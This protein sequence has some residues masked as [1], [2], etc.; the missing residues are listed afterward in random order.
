MSSMSLVFIWL[1]Q[2]IGYLPGGNEKLKEK[3]RNILSPIKQFDKPTNCFDYLKD[4]IKDK[5]VL[6]LTT[7]S[8]A[9]QDFLHSIAS[10]PNVIF[11]YI[12]DTSNQDYAINDQIIQQKMGEQRIIHFDEILYE[13]LIT[14]L[15]FLYQNQGEIL[16]KEKQNKEAKQL[17]QTAS[18]LIDNIEEKDQ[19]L[20]QIQTDLLAKIGK[21]K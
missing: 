5:R 10:L 18:L 15:V 2:R 14:D 13:Q 7:K 1:D 11:M 20:Q 16:L 8:F 4:S 6:F 17:F 9:Q 19:D 3:F 21:I 12:Y